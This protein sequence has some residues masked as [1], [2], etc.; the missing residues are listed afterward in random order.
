LNLGRAARAGA[1]L[2]QPLTIR[3]AYTPQITRDGPLLVRLGE[4]A[5]EFTDPADERADDPAQT[6]FRQF[7][8]R[9]FAGVFPAE[10]YFDGLMP[11]AGGLWARL[12]SLNLTQFTS[13]DGWLALGYEWSPAASVT[14]TKR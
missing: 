5:L 11:P 1:T 8:R 7:L 14:G 10:L 13:R 2:E 6:G 9:K 3:V 4:V 12:R